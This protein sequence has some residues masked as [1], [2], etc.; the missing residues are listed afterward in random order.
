M[1]AHV[2]RRG[3]Q[4]SSECETSQSVELAAFLF[5][6]LYASGVRHTFGVPGDFVLPLYAAQARSRLATVVVTHEPSAGFAADA[7]ARVRGLGVAIGTYGAG[8]LNMVNAIAEAYA[9]HSPVLVIS[10]APEIRGRNP[11]ALLHHRV[12]RFDSQLAI[13]RELTAASAVLEEAAT[14]AGEV[15]RVLGT[16]LRL[17][18]PG[19][20]EV[21]RDMVNAP[22][23]P[24][25]R[26]RPPLA[27]QEGTEEERREAF[28]EIAQ[29][30]AR[31][32]RPAILA[33]VDIERF[34]LATSLRRVAERLALPVST[35]IDGKAVF[36][37]HHPQFVG[38]YMGEMGSAVARNVVEGADC[39]LILGAYLTDTAT[40]LFTSQID[41]RVV[42]HATADSVSVSYHTYPDVTL[43]Q[44]IEFLSRLQA[45]PIQPAR[46][47]PPVPRE[48][49]PAS[50]ELTTD[51]VLDE[52]SRHGSEAVSFTVDSG[53]CLFACA[54]LNADVIINPGYYASMGFAVPAAL[55]AAL[56]NPRRV[57]VAVVG[58]G[59]FQMTGTEISTLVSQGARAVVVLLNN[60]GFSSM[61]GLDRPRPYFKTAAWDYQA[62]ARALGARATQVVDRRGLR[63]AFGRALRSEGVTLI[64]VRLRQDA[65]SQALRRMGAVIRARRVGRRR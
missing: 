53:D 39:L 4:A 54:R 46:Q 7:Y 28:D 2:D 19:Y 1:T 34:G 63:A 30:L 52:L 6:R 38:T 48:P 31:S 27:T 8:A 35:S 64:E 3:L 14:A 58:D 62:F 18:R 29:R 13:Y 57:A 59:A 60:S 51:A 11:D 40:G 16:M 55:G 10:G 12:K 25:S 41:R 43:P 61:A 45:R 50:H 5:D 65:V 15:E 47:L 36:P 20:I 44:V 37:E 26:R 22:L 32:R 9:E 49:E 21:P 24:G 23:T 42:I 17:K 56:A 33:G